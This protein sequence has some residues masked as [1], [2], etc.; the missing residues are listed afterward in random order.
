[1]LSTKQLNRLRCLRIVPARTFRGIIKEE[2]YVKEAQYP[3]IPQYFSENEAEFAALK[4]QMRKLKTV[5]EKQLYLNK[6]KYYGWYSCVMDPNKVLPTSLEFLQFVTNTTI[7]NDDLP[8]PLKNLENIAQEEAQRLEPIIKK[9]LLLQSQVEQGFQVPND[10]AEFQQVGGN[11]ADR[12]SYIR[13]GSDYKLQNLHRIL[14]LHLSQ[15]HPHLMQQ[16]TAF[17]PRVEA[18]WMRSG[19]QPD[20]KMVRR[21]R[22]RL[23]YKRKKKYPKEMLD[24]DEDKMWQEYDNALQIKGTRHT[25]S[26]RMFVK[27]YEIRLDDKIYHVSNISFSGHHCLHVRSETLHDQ[28][29]DIEDEI[30]QS[31]LEKYKIPQWNYASKTSGYPHF[32]QHAT[33]IPGTWT[34]TS[35]PFVNLAYVNSFNYADCL[36]SE[37]AWDP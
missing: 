15:N 13:K 34:G 18:F 8:K 29:I 11:M 22:G 1:M 24:E 2:E 23:E 25:Y 36:T 28:F 6:P 16:T 4:E 20:M 32:N 9:H 14:H 5:E 12:H 19:M 31:G 27:N 37:R 33:N 3:E 30:C 35:H 26:S 21:R 10:R 7:V 17:D